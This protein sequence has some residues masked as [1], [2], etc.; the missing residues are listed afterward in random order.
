VVR[1]NQQR[2]VLRLCAI[3]RRCER[4]ERSE[5]SV[6][7]SRSAQRHCAQPCGLAGAIRASRFEMMAVQEN[8]RVAPADCATGIP[9]QSPFYTDELLLPTAS[10]VQRFS[11]SLLSEYALERPST[12][13]FGCPS[14]ELQ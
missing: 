8:V 2:A 14:Q 3:A 12:M 5:V 6:A 1:Q 9:I 7:V 10:N 4:R 11:A 13:G